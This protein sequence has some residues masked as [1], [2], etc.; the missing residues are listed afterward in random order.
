MTVGIVLVVL[1]AAG[2]A[3]F[4]WACIRAGKDRESGDL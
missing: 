4:G 1:A 3:L 2:L